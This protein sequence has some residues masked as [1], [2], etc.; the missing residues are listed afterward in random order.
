MLDAAFVAFPPTSCTSFWKTAYDSELRRLLCVQELYSGGKDC[1][2]LAWVPVLRASDVEEESSSTEVRT[3]NF[4]L[5][6]DFYIFFI[7]RLINY[8]HPL[9]HLVANLPPQ[10][11]F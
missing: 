8:S 7:L 11:F 1:N 3:D 2:I 9:R 6:G 5:T 4:F 10:V